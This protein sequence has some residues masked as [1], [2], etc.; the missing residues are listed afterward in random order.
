MDEFLEEMKDECQNEN[1]CD[2]MYNALEETNEKMR[3]NVECEANEYD[4]TNGRLNDSIIQMAWNEVFRN[5]EWKI[6]KMLEPI[7]CQKGLGYEEEKVYD[8]NGT[9]IGSKLRKK[10]WRENWRKKVEEIKENDEKIGKK[11]RKRKKNLMAYA[12]ENDMEYL[13]DEWDYDENEL[14][15]EEIGAKSDTRNFS[16]K[17]IFL[18][19]ETGYHLFQWNIYV[20]AK[21]KGWEYPYITNRAIWKGYNDFETRCKLK[22]MDYLLE[23]WDYE[24]NVDLNPDQ[25]SYRNTHKQ[26]YWKIKAKHPITGEMIDLKWT[27]TTYN[28]YCG[29]KCSYLNGYKVLS[30]YNDLSTLRPDIAEE[31]DYE[32]NE[33][34]KPTDCS[35]GSTKCVY[36]KCKKC[37]NSWKAQ[38]TDRTTRGY[39]CSKCNSCK[40]T[41]FPE[42]AIFYYLSKY[43]TDIIHSYKDL[44]FEL[45]IYLPNQKIGIEYDGMYWHKEA[46]ERDLKKNKK[47]KELGIKLYRIRENIDSLND[48]SEDIICEQNHHSLDSVIKQLIK[49]IF[50]TDTNV[51][52]IRDRFEIDKNRSFLEKQ[53]SLAIKAPNLAKEFHPTKNGTHTAETICCRA[54]YPIWWKCSK[55]GYEWMAS[56]DNRYGHGNGCRNCYYI[57]MEE[58][59]KERAKLRIGEKNIARNGMKM[60][61]I[62]YRN[63]K[64]IDVEFDDGTKVFHVR[65]DSFQKGKVKNK[66]L[67][68]KKS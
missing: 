49:D 12:F 23:E 20:N 17:I 3:E 59:K 30:G 68:Q 14:L 64:D 48:Y 29:S 65:Y 50:N 52:V 25:I 45:D 36:W 21:T 41:S 1:E 40:K 63:N 44:G 57:K 35:L 34:L 43:E 66:N 37:G 7:E 46:K 15:P 60:T 26:I 5:K 8:R 32:K 10:N 67:Q 24:A 53:N 18:C 19:N 39:G 62:A 4:G 61:I 31:W 38:I 51:D 33:N 28:R 6:E 13:L 58:E 2:G 42:Y 22:H 11:R 55:C 16:W 9:W 27:T 56:P 47:C 54:R